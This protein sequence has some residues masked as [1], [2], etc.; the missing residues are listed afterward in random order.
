[1]GDGGDYVDWRQRWPEVV[2]R[3]DFIEGV[4]AVIVEKDNRPRWSPPRLEE[5]GE[6][7][8]RPEIEE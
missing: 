2:V 4:R 7:L 3:P 8:K 6:R 5:V 1:M